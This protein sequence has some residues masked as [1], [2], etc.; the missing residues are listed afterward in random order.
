MEN[1]E[2]KT[3]P[4]RTES[5]P[6][7][8]RGYPGGNH[9]PRGVHAKACFFV[10]DGVLTLPEDPTKPVNFLLDAWKLLDC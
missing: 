6:M 7:T 5:S 3:A 9:V 8:R 1:G 2:C 4:P 10:A